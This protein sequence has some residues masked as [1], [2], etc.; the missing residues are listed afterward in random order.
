[1]AEAVKEADCGE[2]AAL[3]GNAAQV[4]VQ[5]ALL[6]EAADAVGGAAL[7]TSG[8]VV[9]VVARSHTKSAQYDL[10]T[11]QAGCPN[12]VDA[13]L[14]HLALCDAEFEATFATSKAVFSTLPTW[15]QQAA[16]KKHRL[17]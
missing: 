14:K 16:K 7:A 13:R 1:M 5:A 4:R 8:A 17:F 12:G 3:P 6:A 2:T 9:E 10:A 15:Q 11:L